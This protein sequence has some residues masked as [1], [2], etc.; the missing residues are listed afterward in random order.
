MFLGIYGVGRMWMMP[1][2]MMM[3]VLMK[4]TLKSPHYYKSYLLLSPP[5]CPPI[6][7]QEHLISQPRKFHH[8][9]VV[10]IIGHLLKYDFHWYVSQPIS[11]RP[12]KHSFWAGTKYIFTHRI[13]MRIIFVYSLT[14]FLHSALMLSIPLLATN[15]NG[16]DMTPSQVPV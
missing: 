16:Y 8:P 12:V 1:R 7:P 5:V 11:N 13:I 2:L 4:K 3:V 10:V 9:L 6:I 14:N 15:P